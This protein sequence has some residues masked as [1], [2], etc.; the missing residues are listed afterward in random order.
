MKLE[1]KTLDKLLN[2]YIVVLKRIYKDK[3]VK[4]VLFGSYA[5]G[6]ARDDSDID[7]LAVIDEDESVLL[8]LHSKLLEDT[9]DFIFDNNDIDIQIVDM[10]A[11]YYNNYKNV[12]MLLTNITE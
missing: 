7:I 5:R 3:L 10:D 2:Q 12:D 11:C 8:Q 1:Q 4:V 6:E 9:F